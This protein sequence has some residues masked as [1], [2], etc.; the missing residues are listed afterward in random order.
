MILDE[1]T[2]ALD[3]FN[4]LQIIKCIKNLKNNNKVIIIISHEE[5]ILKE[6]DKI[7]K[8]EKIN[9]LKYNENILKRNRNFH[10]STKE[11]N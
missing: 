1:A 3:K 2:N 10:L 8:L 7:Y 11:K 6:C 9:L 4:K 5:E